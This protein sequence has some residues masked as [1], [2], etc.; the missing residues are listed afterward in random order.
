MKLKAMLIAFA[1]LALTACGGG[2]S[3]ST[4]AADTCTEL[5]GDSFDCES[6]LQD[7]QTQAVSTVTVLNTEIATLAQNVTTYC[8]DVTSTVNAEIAQAQFKSVMNSVQQLE[9]M[10]FGPIAEFRDE[11]YVWPSNNTCRADDQMV[12]LINGAGETLSSARSLTAV[13][14]MLFEADTLESCAE[15]FPTTVGTWKTNTTVLN[16]RKAARCEYA[17]FILDDLV[18]GVTDLKTSVDA[19]DFSTEFSSLQL[20][21]NS[22][23][24]ALFYVDKQTKDAKVKAVLP[25]TTDGVFTVSKVESQFANTSKANI[26]NN[27]IATKALIN[28]GLDDYL[29]AKGQQTLVNNMIAALDTASANVAAITGELHY[30]VSSAVANDVEA[31]INTTDCTL[32]ANDLQSFCALQYSMKAFTDLLKEDFVLALSFSIPATADG[33]ND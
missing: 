27:L 16:D 17:E 22:I 25:Q 26:Q 14:Y 10:Q 2:G 23:S 13:E 1:A 18:T 9:V 11:L 7:I 12:K 15:N 8:A 6:M 28:A 4:P 33:D 32:A 29:I 5:S 3:G 31:C 24:D 30:V 21:A 19:Y 20:A